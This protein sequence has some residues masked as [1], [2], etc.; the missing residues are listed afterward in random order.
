M[1]EFRK[2]ATQIMIFF[3]HSMWAENKN[4]YNKLL[5]ANKKLVKCSP[6]LC[7]KKHTVGTNFLFLHF[8]DCIYNK[9]PPMHRDIFRLQLTNNRRLIENLP[10]PWL[11]AIYI[12]YNVKIWT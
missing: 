8:L 6:V 10:P 5:L 3:P 12:G 7:E 9:T 4:K 11:N 2:N 1:T